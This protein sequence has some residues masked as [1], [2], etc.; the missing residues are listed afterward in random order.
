MRLDIATLL[1][2]V[3]RTIA[4]ALTALKT[5]GKVLEMLNMENGL[6]PQ[7]LQAIEC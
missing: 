1:D 6:T 4:G 3:C 2:L 7:D 5:L